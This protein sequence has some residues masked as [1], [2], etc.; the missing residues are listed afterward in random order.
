M[1]AYFNEGILPMEFLDETFSRM[2]LH[3]KGT[4][5]EIFEKVVKEVTTEYEQELYE[6]S[7]MLEGY[8][9]EVVRE[10]QS[11]EDFTLT[12]VIREAGVR[13]LR[14]CLHDNL[15][16]FLENYIELMLYLKRVPAEVITALPKWEVLGY[17]TEETTLEEVQKKVTEYL[18]FVC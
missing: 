15:Y 4:V 13:C 6:C 17:V 9:N 16:T 1:K 14:D 12:T 7:Y 10:T 11:T 8:I 18:K 3:K 5:K 2:L